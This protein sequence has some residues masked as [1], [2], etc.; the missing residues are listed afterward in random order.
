MAQSAEKSNVYGYP[1]IIRISEL[2]PYL[3]IF[4]FYLYAAVSIRAQVH[5]NVTLKRRN[6]VHIT[7]VCIMICEKRDHESNHSLFRNIDVFQTYPCIFYTIF[8]L[9]HA[10][11][12]SQVIEFVIH[13][14]NLYF[15]IK[16]F[17]SR[18]TLKLKTYIWV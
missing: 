5:F 17:A 12:R 8:L 6:V 16:W 15:Y 11:I 7:N 4:F 2:S 14:G 9:K 1:K 13:N 3:F 10:F 18:L